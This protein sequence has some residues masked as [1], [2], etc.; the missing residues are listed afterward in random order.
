M[1]RR[2]LDNPLVLAVLGLLLEQPMHPYQ[3]HAEL[4]TRGHAPASRGSLYDIV[5]A[6]V[7]ASWVAAQERERAGNRPERTIY[8]LTETGHAELV[9]RLDSQIRTPRRESP[10]FLGAVAYLGAL[11]SRGGIDALG[12]RADRLGARIEDDQARLAE[13]LAADVP[14]L[15]VIEAEYAL[16]LARAELAWIGTVIEDLRTGNL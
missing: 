7:G 9:R 5:E 15:H 8:A 13:V 3:M 4:R 14:R 16:A 1:P 6:L 10:E 2:A 11:G 12:E